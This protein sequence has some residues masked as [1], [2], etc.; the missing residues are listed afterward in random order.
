MQINLEENSVTYLGN[1]SEPWNIRLIN[2]TELMTGGRIK[3]AKIVGHNRF[4]L[5]Y[6]DGVAN[7]NIRNLIKSHE[8]SGLLVTLIMYNLKA[9]TTLN[10]NKVIGI[11][12]FNEKPKGDNSWVNGGFFVAN[13][14]FSIL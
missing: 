7:V 1:R 4:L 10:I 12:S 13:Q 2:G 9:D 11:I 5:T 14:K 8:T 6:G 3:R